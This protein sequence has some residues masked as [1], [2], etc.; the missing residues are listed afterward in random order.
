MP[1]QTTH[2]VPERAAASVPDQTASV[3]RRALA[4]N[5]EQLPAPLQALHGGALLDWRGQ[6][7]V[8]RGRG[9]LARL[10][11]AVVGFPAQGRDVDVAVRI[12]H[13]AGVERWQRCFAGRVFSS[14]LSPAGIC[15]ES[16]VRERF[17][18]VTVTLALLFDGARLH[19]VTRSWSVLGMPLP[20]AW[21]PGGDTYE[22]AGGD[23]RFCFHIEIRQ[24]LLGLIV[25]YDG[26]LAPHR[27]D[28]AV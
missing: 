21:A 6:A 9:A 1:G 8:V 13:G 7:A 10:V 4:Q 12:E 15:A 17:G 23:G 11:G 5:W 19:F 25:G 27:A 2:R 18:P 22:Y 28:D 16:T 14:V 24:A 26:W 3:F 20:R